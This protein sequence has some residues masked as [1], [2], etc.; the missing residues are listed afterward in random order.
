VQQSVIDG[1]LVTR[2]ILRATF[3]M[4]NHLYSD[5]VVNSAVLS[6]LI[7]EASGVHSSAVKL[8]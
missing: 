8:L 6:Q 5:E 7:D 3:I 2:M 1:S 4:T